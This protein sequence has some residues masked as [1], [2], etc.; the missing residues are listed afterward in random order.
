MPMSSTTIRSQRQMRATV[1]ATVPSTF[2]LLIVVVSDS[3]VNQATRRSCSIAAYAR[4]ST[5]W[6]LP[7]P[8]GP[9]T[10]RFSTR[11]I[12]SHVTRACWV[13]WG[14]EDSSGRQLANVLPVGKL[15]ALR[16]IRRVAASRPVTS[17]ASSTRSTSAGS[18]RWA[19]AVASTSGAAVRRYGRRMRRRMRSSSSGI[20]GA[21]G[22][23]TGP[24]SPRVGAGLPRVGLI[25][26]DHIARLPGGAQVV[27]DR[28]EVVLGE[29]ARDGGQAQR[30]VD[31]PGAEDTGQLDGLGHLGADP[32]GAGGAGL[33]QPAVRTLAEPKEGD[34][35]GGAWSGLGRVDPAA[36]GMV[37]VVLVGDARSAWRGQPVAAQLL[38]AVG[39]AADDDQLLALGA[40]PHGLAAPARRGRVPHP[41]PADRLVLL[42]QPVGTQRQRVR[43]G[44]KHVQVRPLGGQPHGRGLPVLAV[45]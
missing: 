25:S 20:G 8:L 38:Q 37:G 14:M 15:A 30:L 19:L 16:R 10:A 42:H 21:V 5:K 31:L 33:D 44:R 34:L 35:L 27:Q 1:R 40:A 13:A 23:L 18:Q 45:L 2:A 11:P 7:V 9:A 12:H 3:S 26:P 41:A 39:T 43:G 4:A 36:A 32:G 22:V 6:L 24:T 29:P 17:S 28:G